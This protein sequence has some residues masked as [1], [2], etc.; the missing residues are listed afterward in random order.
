MEIP[1]LSFAFYGVQA[2][3]VDLVMPNNITGIVNTS[4]M[5]EK[6]NFKSITLHSNINQTYQMNSMFKDAVVTTNVNFHNSTF[7]NIK[8]ISSLFEN[9]EVGG[10][11]LI[12]IRLA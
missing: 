12:L 4:S 1:D 11:L 5:F 8:N 3:S 2:P 7:P 9:A 10:S 6:S